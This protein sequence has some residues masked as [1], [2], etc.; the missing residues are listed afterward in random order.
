MPTGISSLLRRRSPLIVAALLSLSF[1][2]ACDKPAA[3]GGGATASPGDGPPKPEYE[4]A[5]AEIDDLPSQM[6]A[7]VRWAAQ[8]ISDTA[9]LAN[10]VA[11]LRQSVNVDAETFK[12][13]CKVAF[14]DGKIEIGAQAELQES[15]AEIEATLMKI[16]Q[17]GQDLIGIPARVK[18]AGK[19][20]TK[21]VTGSPGLA[22]KAAKELKGEIKVATGDRKVKLEAD[23]KAVTSL[24]GDLKN[25]AVAL[26]NDLTALPGEAKKATAN[27]IAAFA[28]QPL[29]HPDLGAGAEASADAGA[30][31]GGAAPAG[32]APAPAAGGTPTPTGGAPA[33]TPAP[34]AGGAPAGGAGGGRSVPP[35][36]SGG[37]PAPTPTP[38]PAPAPTAAAPTAVASTA[39]PTGPAVKARIN[40]LV[41]EAKQVSGHGDWKTAS[42]LYLDAYYLDLNDHAMAFKVGDAAWN[43]KDCPLST[44]YLQHF[45]QYGD[46]SAN[47]REMTEAGKILKELRTFDCPPRTSSD[48]AALAQTMLEEGRALGAGGD[49]GGAAASFATAYQVVPEDHSFAFEVA[50]ASWNA[51]ECQDAATYFGHFLTV[52]DSKAHRR[53]IRDAKKYK[54][55]QDAGE[56]VPRTPSDKDSHARELYNQA[57]NLEIKLDY[58]RAV[59]KYERAHFLMP[60]NHAFLYRIGDAAWHARNCQQADD[61]LRKFAA[62]ATDPRYATDLAASQAIIAKLDAH[63]CPNALWAGDAGGGAAAPA[64]G[65]AAPVAG[66]GPPPSG[67]SGGAKSCSVTA[68]SDSS[69]LWTLLLLAAVPRRRRD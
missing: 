51:K 61:Y 60:N 13:M 49:W 53:Q 33:P 26:K 3:G 42:R 63:G 4:S 30:G 28:G 25:E 37:A 6:G 36:P 32:G 64:A 12:A 9:I 8:P 27:M 43:A 34:A 58:K 44:R 1:V 39:Q 59:G 45:S 47:A 48:E 19:N 10:E 11:K 50:M 5:F 62:A 66:E 65:G 35:P 68:E 38:A 69:W 15:R 2:A 52:A 29:P 31:A 57:Q 24:P 17:T 41:S 22:M 46:K 20:L 56:C 7:Q 16:K 21:M 14:K 23:L 67:G 55:K 54:A 18:T 40:A